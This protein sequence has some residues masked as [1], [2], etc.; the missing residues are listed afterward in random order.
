VA[1]RG[2]GLLFLSG[3]VAQDPATGDLVDGDIAQ[4]ADQI[5]RNVAAALAA[6]GKNLDDVNLGRDGDGE[7]SGSGPAIHRDD[8]GWGQMPGDAGVVDAEQV[9]GEE[10]A[11]IENNLESR[12]TKSGRRESN[13]HDQLGRLGLC[14]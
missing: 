12:E 13:P 14:H 10:V 11:W 5:L 2:G 8:L 4:Q 1:V 7:A 3:Q 6:I 9:S